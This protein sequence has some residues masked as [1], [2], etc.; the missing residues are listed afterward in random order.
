[1]L[2]EVRWA[3]QQAGVEEQ[4]N[5]MLERGL[6]TDNSELRVGFDVLIVS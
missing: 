1:M 2:A 5:S 3:V 4:F 6:H